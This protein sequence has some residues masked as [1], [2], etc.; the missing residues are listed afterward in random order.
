MTIISLADEIGLQP[1][2]KALVKGF[3]HEHEDSVKAAS[4]YLADRIREDTL[5]AEDIDSFINDTL[6]LLPKSKRPDV[7]EYLLTKKGILLCQ[8]G[9]I[10][11]GLKFYAEA[12]EVKET[13]S[14][15]ALKGAAFLQVNL[16]DEAF[17]AF[18]KAF[19]L[20]Q[21]FGVQKQEYLND[22][23]IAW[24]TSAL[25]R[26]LGGILDDTLSEAQNGVEEF[27]GVSSKANAEGLGTSLAHLGVDES[28]S[29]N[30]KSAL[31]ELDLMVRLLSIEDPFEGWRELSKEISK[32]WPHDVSA[33]DEIREQRE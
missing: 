31:D 6:H 2:D 13:P 8:A 27:L 28:A 22:L 10:V 3:P 23:I 11:N 24:S 20:R 29:A 32:V 21:E 7:L 17:H 5:V 12:L 4:G 33:V 18:E 15:W 14:T 25:L 30:L 16:L 9:A 19:D 26:G 1:L